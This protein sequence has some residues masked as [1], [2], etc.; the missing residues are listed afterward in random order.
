MARILIIDDN[1]LVR[2]ALVLLLEREGHEV[3]EACDGSHALRALDACIPDLVITDINM[4]EMEGFQVIRDL[5]KIVPGLKII[6]ISGGGSIG[7][8]DVLKR[9]SEV[10][11][12][13]AFA[14]PIDRG[15]FLESVTRL[16]TVV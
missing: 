6:A 9:A 11:A 14:K 5:R 15:E 3:L 16:L 7:C 1:E 10:G 13:K 8:Q 2:A 4:P 12:D